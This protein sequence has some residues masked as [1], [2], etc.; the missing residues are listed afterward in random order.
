M[1]KVEKRNKEVIVKHKY[2]DDCGVEIVKGGRIKCQ[3]CGKDL[4]DKCVGYEIY[5]SGDNRTVYCSKCWSIGEKYRKE[6]E[7]LENK[8]DQLSDEWINKCKI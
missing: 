7:T 2:C 1:I 8:I 6:I 5:E 3:I 4:C